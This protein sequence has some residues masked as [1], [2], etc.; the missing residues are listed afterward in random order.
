MNVLTKDHSKFI[1]FLH[2]L[3]SKLGDL[4]KGNCNG[5]FTYTKEILAGYE[6]INIE[7]TILYFQRLGAFCDCQITYNIVL[8]YKN[9]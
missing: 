7:D 3:E 2:N 5:D 6:D 8:G 9:V 1:D 4:K